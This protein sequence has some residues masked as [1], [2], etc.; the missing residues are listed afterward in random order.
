MGVAPIH[1]GLIM[2]ANLT[3]GLATPPFGL[4]LFAVCGISK[5]TLTRVSIGILPFLTA[6][7]VVL[8]LITYIPFITMYFPTLFGF[9]G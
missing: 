2:C 6:E 7:V 4:V 9:S 1:F 8:L 5:V 3:I